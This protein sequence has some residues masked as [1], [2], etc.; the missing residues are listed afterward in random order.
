MSRIRSELRAQ[1]LGATLGTLAVLIALGGP[2]E[3]VNSAA[4]VSASI[5]SALKIAKRADK[6]SKQALRLAQKVSAK[7]GQQG[8]KGDQGAP[9]T[10]DTG[11]TAADANLLDGL[12]SSAFVQGN[13]EMRS[14]HSDLE[15]AGSVALFEVP[16]VGRL[17]V[18]CRNSNPIINDLTYRNLSSSN[19]SWTREVVDQG[20]GL[21]ISGGDVAQ[22]TNAPT[23]SSGAFVTDYSFHY[24][25][26]V[27][28]PAGSAGPA[29]TFNVT[30]MLY[31][32]GQ[33]HCVTHGTAVITS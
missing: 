8:A 20:N 4:N 15:A 32:D 2:A 7:T 22:N 16:G 21:L 17:T 25:L 28:P 24:L 3:A 11:A 27:H 31:P 6:R 23:Y 29:I 12:D 33:A 13:G 30:G 5:K 14:A 26:T 19:Q 9:G 1:W 10:V 18:A